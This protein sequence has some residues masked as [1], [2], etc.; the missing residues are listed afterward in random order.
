MPNFFREVAK[1]A[2]K[3]EEALLGPDYKYWENIKTPQEIGM[4]SDGNL[5][6]LANDIGGLIN[7]VELLVTGKTKASATGGPLGDKF[8]L[9]TGAT[10]K[11][12]QTGED[13]TRYIYINNIP[14]GNIPF[15]SSGMGVNFSEFEG[16]IPG[17][18]SKVADVNPMAIFG[19]FMAEANPPCREIELETVDVNNRRSSESHHMTDD[20]IRKM[21]PCLFT[22]RR[23]PITNK[24]CRETFSTIRR[25]DVK[26]DNNYVYILPKDG[27]SKMFFIFMAALIFYMIYLAANKTKKR[28]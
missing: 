4:S 25:D 19:A 24:R 10:C 5:G 27:I 3:V 21:D 28:R 22:E 11:D 15:I 8:F 6:A 1:D 13:A 2:K 14:N 16:L 7:Y 9:K 12:N 23:N 18:M 26:V 17:A 20:D